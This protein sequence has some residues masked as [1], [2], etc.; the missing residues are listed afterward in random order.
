ML[1]HTEGGIQ[2]SQQN[3]WRDGDGSSTYDCRIDNSV[4][5]PYGFEA[6]IIERYPPTGKTSEKLGT[7]QS[8]Y[9]VV[10]SSVFIYV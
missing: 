2:G 5:K 1:F 10:I 6:S 4:D 9:E 3:H 7:L 8:E